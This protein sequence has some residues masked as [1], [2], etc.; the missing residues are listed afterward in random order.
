[1]DGVLIVPKLIEKQG[2]GYKGK[3]RCNILVS[4]G[5]YTTVACGATSEG[6]TEFKKFS[7]ALIVKRQS[8]PSD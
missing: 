2:L 1:M 3:P 7:F 8:K 6:A 4:L 5:I